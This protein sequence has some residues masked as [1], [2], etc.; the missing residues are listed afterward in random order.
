MKLSGGGM[1]G[2]LCERWSNCGHGLEDF[3]KDTGA[4]GRRILWRLGSGCCVGGLLCEWR[5]GITCLFGRGPGF[6]RGFSSL[7]GGGRGTAGLD[8]C[9][10]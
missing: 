4:G 3:D 2:L 1:T 9:S 8:E 10:L 6:G 7:N 5:G